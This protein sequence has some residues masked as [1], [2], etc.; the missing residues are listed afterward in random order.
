M[1]SEVS[2][3]GG[4]SI[5]VFP[6]GEKQWGAIELNLIRSALTCES[7]NMHLL[8]GD[9]VRDYYSS[10]QRI[11]VKMEASSG[12]MIIFETFGDLEKWMKT[13]CNHLWPS[14]NYCGKRYTADEVTCSSC[15]GPRGDD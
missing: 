2:A 3:G 11:S 14:C 15:G 6:F 13:K 5:Q 4:F 10:Q 7:E 8:G 1:F 12:S 9:P